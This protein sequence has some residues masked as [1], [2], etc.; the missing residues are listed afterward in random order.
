MMKKRMMVVKTMAVIVL[1]LVMVMPD[2]QSMAAMEAPGGGDPDWYYDEESYNW[3]YKK[4]G[5]EA[6]TGWLNFDGEWYWFDEAGRMTSGGEASIDGKKFYFFVNGNMA[7]NQYV[8]MKFYDGEGQYDDKYDI[9]VIGNQAPDSEEKDLLSDYLY[10]IPRTWLHSF[11]RSGW[12]LMLYTEKEFFAAPKEEDGIYYVHH[13]TDT[14]YQKIKFT[15]ADSVLQ[16]FG[17]YLGYAAGCYQEDSAWMKQ[18]WKD[19]DTLSTFIQIPKY[20][21]DDAQFCFGKIFAAYMDE[22]TYIE[23]A[24]LTPKTCRV[25]EEILRMK[26]NAKTRKELLQEDMEKREEAVALA[27]RTSS[28]KYGPGVEK[29]EEEKESDSDQ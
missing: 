17:E 25:I 22:K 4:N 26:E 15:D 23:M 3:Y 10:Q 11:T 7:R 18:V 9:R 16:G 19:M 5:G 1:S 8:G 21:K 29:A 27:L 24:K 20:Y 28:Y 6:H 14:R 12:E 13:D 2:F